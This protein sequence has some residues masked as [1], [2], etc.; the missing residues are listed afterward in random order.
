MSASLL[1][2]PDEDNWHCSPAQTVPS[3]VGTARPV[4]TPTPPTKVC[5]TS[6]WHGCWNV[7]DA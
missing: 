1:E 7:A 4:L 6:A 3:A 2:R 5:T